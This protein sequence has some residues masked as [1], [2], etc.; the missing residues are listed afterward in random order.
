MWL[1][2][3]VRISCTIG[4]AVFGGWRVAGMFVLFGRTTLPE[5]KNSRGERDIAV[6]KVLSSNFFF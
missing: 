1:G 4:I 2:M 5:K 6:I 3:L